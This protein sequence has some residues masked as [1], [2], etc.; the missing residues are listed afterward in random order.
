MKICL[1][2]PK[3]NFISH[4]PKFINFWNSNE[5]IRSYRQNWSGLTPALPIIASLIGEEH[6]VTIID[7][8]IEMIDFT[9]GYDLI[10]ITS[11]TQQ[12]IRAYEIADQF[13]RRNV[14]VVLGGIHPTVLPEE[15]L[16]HADAVV[17]GEAEYVW[18]TVLEDLCSGNLKKIYK[19]EGLVDLGS[20]SQVPNYELLCNKNYKVIWVQNSRGCPHDCEFCA[21]SKVFGQ[22]YRIKNPDQVI[23]EINTIKNNFGNIW[24]AFGDDNFIV[25]KKKSKELLEKIANLN[26]RWACESDISVAEDEEILLLLRKSGCSFLFTGLESLDEQ[27][28][29]NIDRANWKMKKRKY[30][31]EYINKIQ[32][33]GIGVM[34]SF[35]IGLENDYESV[36]QNITDFII[37]TNL[38]EANISILTPFPGTRLR[39][40]LEKE[41]RILPTNWDNYTLYDVNIHHR[42]LT[43]DQM[44][45]GLLKIYQTIHSE[46]NYLRKMEHFKQIQIK[47]IKKG[48]I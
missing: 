7:E 48:L 46:K 28:L 6:E 17:V 19:S 33:Y 45:D 30:Y 1:I 14:K 39:E 21:A 16:S 27:G 47:L 31:A 18:R 20:I 35:I 2:Y 36:F 8:N 37:E 10:G 32:S 15:A 11:M 3:S 34:G 29:L 42:H 9:K 4:S 5:Y 26:I 13:R 41:K 40:R 23:N 43:K 25:N 12:A 22:K 24:I 38:F 44:E